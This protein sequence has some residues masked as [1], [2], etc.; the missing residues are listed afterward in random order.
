MEHEEIT[1]RLLDLAAAIIAADEADRENPAEPTPIEGWNI[2]DIDALEDALEDAV[3]DGY[4]YPGER[5][6][7]LFLAHRGRY[8]DTGPAP[9]SSDPRAGL[10][11]ARALLGE[12]EEQEG[13]SKTASRLKSAG[14]NVWAK[15]G[16]FRLYAPD[17]M[18]RSGLPGYFGSAAHQPT[19]WWDENKGRWGVDCDTVH[20]GWIAEHEDDLFEVLDAAYRPE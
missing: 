10:R 8:G 17:D 5:L 6:D 13:L 19:I 11:E 3:E 20:R 16:H 1:A 7:G 15:G 9:L 2:E 12:D 14:W 18:D 4:E